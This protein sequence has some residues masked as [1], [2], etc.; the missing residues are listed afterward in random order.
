MPAGE[1]GQFRCKWLAC[2]LLRIQ[3]LRMLA[4][5][6]LLAWSSLCSTQTVP[7]SPA[8]DSTTTLIGAAQESESLAA[9]RGLNVMQVSIEGVAAERLA[10][11]TSK[12]ALT[13]GAPLSDEKLQQSLRQLYATGLFDSLQ[14][15]GSHDGGG[16]KVVFRGQARA[17]IGTVTVDGA[18]GSTVNAQLQRAAQLAAGARFTQ[19]KLDRALEQMK[20]ALAENGYYQPQIAHEVHPRPEDQLIDIAF[21]VVSGPQSRVGA[22]QVAGDPGLTIDEFR[23]Y[24]RLRNGSR[25]DHDTNNRAVDG[26]LRHYGKQ[27]RLEAEIKLDDQQY[28]A[29]TNRTAF[30]FTANQ[31]PRVKVRVEGASLSQER[32]KRLIPV[33]AEG[34]VDDDLLNEGNRRLRDYY[35]RLGYFDV[36]VDHRQD[37]SNGAQVAI[38]YTVQLGPRQHVGKVTLDGNKYFGAATLR[39]LLSVHAAD[40]LDRHGNYSQ[41]LVSADVSALEAVYKNNG[42]SKVKIT[43]EI[44]AGKMGENANMPTSAPLSVIYHIDEGLQQRVGVV[45]IDGAEHVDAAKLTPLLN[46]VPGQLLSPQNLAG[47]RD[48]LLTEFL[49]RGFDRVRVDV[50]PQDEAGDPAKVDVVFRIAEGQQ[51]FVR[52]VLLTGLH[53]TRPDTVARAITI[54]PGDPLNQSA[55]LETQ[56]NFYEFALFSEIET[57]I[58]NPDGGETNKTVL[59]QAA[60]AR[61]WVFTYGL[62]FEAQ[63]GQP[64][65]NCAGINISSGVK[66]DP[67]GKTGVSPRV[68]GD[69][70]RNNLFGR[71]QSASLRGTY[72]LLEQNVN[73]V[74]QNP[75][76]NGNR[77][78]GLTFSGGYANSQD[79]TTYVA[80]KL[81]VGMRWTEHFSGA[82]RWP[83]RA[84]T[85]IYEFDFRRV[86]VAAS[87]LAGLSPRDPAVV[88]R[89]A[90]FRAGADVDS[91]HAR[92]PAGCAPRH[93]YQLSG[94]PFS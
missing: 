56:R 23:H 88:R 8:A 53:Y 59:I 91:R 25:V 4:L 94:I 14:V 50:I 21:H 62:G 27:E 5:P 29:A 43:P 49:S 13:T 87:S 40:T 48:A 46:T 61:R 19:A 63:T 83:S 76:F 30:Q 64:K 10:P 1:C 89:A 52:K 6:V 93:L 34:S 82:R 38:V 73:L 77:D 7:L 67:E 81:D 60:E 11:I 51:I 84:N 85:L 70:T 31:G 35:Q 55:L 78:F 65:N 39:D 28:A 41:A 71:D 24:A 2:L 54:H 90:R 75:H 45:T 20:Q 47:D 44:S 66:C 33:F 42:F 9:L 16:V 57:A 22:V 37:A 26:V 15:E 80:S 79:V 74:F 32:V 69:L 36:K 72:G 58:E 3:V 92:L 18:K 86:K 68:L 17:F 12:L